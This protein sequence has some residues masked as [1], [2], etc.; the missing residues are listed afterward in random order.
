MKI[1]WKLKILVFVISISA[2]F[3]V[4]FASAAGDEDDRMASCPAAEARKIL[5]ELF[6]R[7]PEID[8]SNYGPSGF[9]SVP[10]ADCIDQI[11]AELS[12][13][14]F[15][16]E[17]VL[18]DGYCPLHRAA[19]AGSFSLVHYLVNDLKADVNIEA[20]DGTTA[21]YWAVSAQQRD[22]VS[23][24]LKLGARPSCSNHRRNGR[25]PLHLAV[26]AVTEFE[27]DNRY[28][29]ETKKALV[30][31]AKTI[32]TTL[33]DAGADINCCNDKGVTPLHVAVRFGST[34]FVRWLL[35]TCVGKID[36]NCVDASGKT[37]LRLAEDVHRPED[38][39][40][41]LRLYD[42]TDACCNCCSIM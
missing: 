19:F 30:S 2:V 42:A 41:L 39:I 4:F 17:E 12:F 21:L 36:V 3:S 16:R 13:W 15:L 34:D 8:G 35:T 24:L 7:L 22:T 27:G 18:Y 26:A 37:P 38:I 11:I 23:L 28:D 31:K 33:M 40:K 29:D 14:R 6:K 1:N 25:T 10:F 32:I 5:H 20:Y 9:L